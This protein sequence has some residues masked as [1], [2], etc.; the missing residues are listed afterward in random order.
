MIPPK[1][2]ARPARTTRPEAHKKRLLLILG[3]AGAAAVA[4][5]VAA[6]AAIKRPPPAPPPSKPAAVRPEFSVMIHHRDLGRDRKISALVRANV[7]FKPDDLVLVDD[8]GGKY[9]PSLEDARECF[10][11][12][13]QGA[14]SGTAVSYRVTS[15]AASLDMLLPD[16]TTKPIYRRSGK[17]SEHPFGPPIPYE[18]W[19]ISA[20]GEL[21]PNFDFDLEI[22]AK[23]AADRPFPI[24]PRDFLL[25]TDQGTVLAP[26]VRMDTDP[27]RLHYAGVPRST[28]MIRFQT[29]FRSE[30]LEYMVFPVAPAEE[31]RPAPAAASKAEPPKH[32]PV[33]GLRARFEA[34]LADPV[35][36]LKFLAESPSAES[37]RLAREGLA[38]FIPEDIAAGLKA[39]VEGREEDAERP[40]VRAALLS[41][42]YSPDLSRQLIRTLLLLKRPRRTTTGCAACGGAGSAPCPACRNGLVEGPCA[43]CGTKGQA[44]CILC[45][46]SGTM[47]HYGFKGTLTLTIP[48]DIRIKYQGRMGTLNAQT[49]TYRMGPCEDGGFALRT[50]SVVSSS[51]AR[52]TDSLRQ[53]CTKFWEEMKLFVFNGKA[54]IQ[55][56]NPQGHTVPLSP[57]AAKRFFADYEHC[58]GGRVTCE[59]CAGR[60]TET[61]PSC[62]GTG[63]AMQLCAECEGASLRAC[64]SCR[65]Y[66]DASW[67]AGL[68]PAGS[69]PEL[70]GALERQAAEIKAWLDERARRDSR[71]GE[72]ARRLEEARKGLDPTAKITPHTLEVTCPRCKGQGGE[73]EE[74]WGAGR[75]EYYE[76]TP[77][78]ERYAAVERL[79]RRLEEAERAP[80]EPPKP[81]IIAAAEAATT[82]GPPKPQPMQPPA[83]QP[84]RPAAALPVPL[85][86]RELI[87]KADAFHETGR[88]HL[89]K[90]KTSSDQAV[91]MEAAARA[92]ADLKQAQ[93]LYTT[94]QEKLDEL[95]VEI[96]RD[97]LQKFR[98]NMQ[99]LV[100]ARRTAP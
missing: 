27:I 92:L 25:I 73:C 12:E 68:L 40:L 10:L 55:I 39:S 77:Q 71:R 65:G 83:D 64:R 96:P 35:A 99:A 53:P 94:A 33:E 90:A 95:G 59:R 89:E 21:S 49:V 23:P 85:E 62:A 88:A 98:L 44:A 19:R 5:I 11:R 31:P 69:A 14:P 54:K 78:Y 29:C 8:R 48:R 97:L 100:M 50:E 72:L 24:N 84:R 80:P 67:L 46:G 45:E 70:C 9:T 58:K 74:C 61:C 7:A 26:Q 76:G 86:V 16:G 81:G 75:R 22:R 60:K 13:I 82:A 41:D 3:C 17:E 2:R 15:E 42:P 57:V 28:R 18:D 38:R 91:W 20:R 52:K 51:G 1:G 66:G 43:R 4:A 36:A 79:K 87:I 30:R 6:T 47:D 34:M 56:L 37:R 93:T 32:P 63:K